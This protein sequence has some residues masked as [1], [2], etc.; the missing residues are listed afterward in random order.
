MKNSKNTQNLW[1]TCPTGCPFLQNTPQIVDKLNFKF[2][3]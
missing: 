2:S 3:N 1:N